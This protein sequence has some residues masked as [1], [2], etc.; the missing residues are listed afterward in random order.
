MGFSFFLFYLKSWIPDKLGALTCASSD[1]HVHHGLTWSHMAG[2]LVQLTSG[3]DGN[4]LSLA[5]LHW[6]L[7]CMDA[8]RPRL[9]IA[10]ARGSGADRCATGQ[11][12]SLS[13]WRWIRS[14]QNVM[15]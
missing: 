6:L 15:L 5:I 12:L 7:C 3:D 10:L 11:S 4:D 2:D 1:K 8:C 14:F 9:T 13:K